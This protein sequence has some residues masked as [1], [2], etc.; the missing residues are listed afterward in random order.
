M[1]RKEFRRCGMVIGAFVGALVGV[2]VA[3]GNAVLPIVALIVGLT[4]EYLCRRRVTEVIEDERILR[5]S[6]KASRSTFQVFVI[7][8][9]VIGAVLTALRKTEYAQFTQAG[10]T[11]AFSACAL[12]ILYLIFYGYYSRKSLD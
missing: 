4:F 1:N 6:E 10:S 5:I 7:T 9:G 8:I 2:S 11:L 12:L 3:A